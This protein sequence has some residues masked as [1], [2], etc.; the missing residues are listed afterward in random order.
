MAARFIR[1][2]ARPPL[3]WGPCAK[4]RDPVAMKTS[5]DSNPR[6]LLSLRSLQSL[7]RVC[8]S[9]AALLCL[10]VN[11]PASAQSATGRVVG[12]YVELAPGV[13]IERA[14]GMAEPGRRM[15][16]EVRVPPKDEQG[17]KLVLIDMNG[18]VAGLGDTVEVTLGEK[19]R[20][21]LTGPRPTPP[22]L[23][24][25]ETPRNTVVVLRP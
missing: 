24:R 25:V 12:L 10:F 18:M 19:G 21:L 3:A 8:A 7:H 13:M 4:Y 15:F 14:A 2:P 11:L 9:L 1:N 6:T 23:V 17:A 5:S 16:A 22:R 20:G